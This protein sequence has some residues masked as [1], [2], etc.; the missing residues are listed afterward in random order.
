MIRTCIKVQGFFESGF[1]DKWISKILS[2]LISQSNPKVLSHRNP[3]NNETSKTGTRMR[4]LVIFLKGQT[5]KKI[6]KDLG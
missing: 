2:I 4:L 5:G 3:N 6:Q 1:L